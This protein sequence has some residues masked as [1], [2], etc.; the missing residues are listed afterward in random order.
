MDATGTGQGAVLV[1]TSG[2]LASAASPAQR[3]GYISIYCTGL[4]PV[5]N[6]PP[7]G[8]GAPTLPLATTL[9]TPSVTIGTL[10]ATVS[11]SGLAPTL[12]GLY[13][14]NAVVPAAT[15]PGNLVPVTL[16]MGNFISNVVTIAVQ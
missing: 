15:I 8:V 4:G 7:T 5:T 13:Q 12:V 9:T 11:Y 1:S 6:Q 2:Q 16:S 14:V 3:G 10:A